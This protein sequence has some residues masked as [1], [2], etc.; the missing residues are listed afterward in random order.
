MTH[1]LHTGIL[2]A[3]FAAAMLVVAFLR[4]AEVRNVD[5]GG[6]PGLATPLY[7]AVTI[8]FMVLL[9][10]AGTRTGRFGFGIP[11]RPLRALALGMLGIAVLQLSVLTIDPMLGKAFGAGRDL[12]RFADVAGAPGALVRLLALSWTFAAFGEELA[13][14]IAL[15][16]GLATAFGDG[17]RAI[18]AAV[19]L[20]AA[21]FGL[22][23][24]YQGPAGVGGAFISGLVFGLV[25]LLGRGSIWPAVIAH[26][27]NNTIGI[28]ALYHGVG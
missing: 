16:R 24:L 23:H 13:F 14:R 10:R 15:M 5:P 26:G 11:I 28:L 18:A 8:A 2:T 3:L 17:R 4:L 19:I 27:G 6:L 1:R 12:G 21:V 22:I 20:Q 25:T 7:V 9:A